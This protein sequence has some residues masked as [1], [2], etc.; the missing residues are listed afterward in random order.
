MN[1]PVRRDISMALLLFACFLR[2]S[3][4]SALTVQDISIKVSH[5]TDKVL[6]S[7]TDQYRKGDEVIISRS[8]NLSD[9]SGHES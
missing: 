2:F 9:M 3:E 4:V 1:F 6:K 7:K 8:H 5:L